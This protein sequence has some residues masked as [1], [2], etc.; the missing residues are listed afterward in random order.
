MRRR[1]QLTGG[2]ATRPGMP[3]QVTAARWLLGAV[4]A[5]LCVLTIA[6]TASAE[7]PFRL[8]QQVTDD[9]GV[10]GQR[11]D[12]VRQALGRLEQETGVLLWVV[13]VDTFSGVPHQQWADETAV[14]SD[15]GTNDILLAVAVVDRSYAY[16]VDPKFRLTDAQ[17]A[18]VDSRAIKPALRASDWAGAAIGGANGYLAVLQGKP[19][20][21]PSIQPGKPLPASGGGSLVPWVLGGVALLAVIGFGIALFVRRSSAR[22][23]TQPGAGV[24]TLEELNSRANTA[25]VHADDSVRTAG[26]EVAFAQAEFGDDEVRAY[27]QVLQE[28][29]ASLTAAFAVRQRL[30]DA[31]PETPDERRALLT[32]IIERC[33]R[34]QQALAAQA[35]TFNSLRDLATRAPDMLAGLSARA[36][37]LQER[38]PSARQTLAKLHDEYESTALTSVQQNPEHAQERLSFARSE[39]EEGRKAVSDGTEGRAALAVRAAEEALDQA[40][41]LLSGVERASSDLAAAVAQLPAATQDLAADLES[42]SRLRG[43]PEQ[44][45]ALGSAVDAARAALGQAAASGR[46]DPLGALR[47]VNEANAAMDAA[48]AGAREAEAN[49]DRA[50]AHLESALLAARAEVGAAEDLI[51]T[52]RGRIG[53]AARTRL[54]EA[55][56]LLADAETTRQT[57]P[58]AALAS[59]QQ[60]DRVAEQA[61][62]AAR[63]DLTPQAPPFGYPGGYGSWGGTW[64]GG[65]GLLDA[66]LRGGFSGGGFGRGPWGGGGSWG[67]GSW[68]GGSRRGGGGG[69]GGGFGGRGSSGG[70]RGGGGRF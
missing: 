50:E 8:Q 29:K 32:E 9:A 12:D 70:R 53:S 63:A 43:G 10:L 5:V 1:Q 42:A 62:A 64:G 49:R 55:Q 14:D 13:Y 22:P 33:E 17:L 3:R 54:V 28:A 27:A 2:G 45:K 20:P 11:P 26:R 52:N 37:Q 68:G 6:P 69:F 23:S 30:D 7:K 34:A 67:G 19:V 35:E 39:L 16:S 21:A 60:A 51:N 38:L 48:L 57:D 31:E 24:E 41:Q 25:L 59:A 18:E 56:R 44:A 4:L 36:D 40:E 66:I 15:F 65:G 47:A 58:V 46:S 61:S